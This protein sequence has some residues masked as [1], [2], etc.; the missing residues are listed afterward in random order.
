MSWYVT[1]FGSSLKR[2]FR[3]DALRSLLS[4]TPSDLSSS[5]LS[6]SIIAPQMTR[7]PTMHPLPA[8]SMPHFFMGALKRGVF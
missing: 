2:K 6:A 4:L 3:F 8:S 7:G 5:S 1:C